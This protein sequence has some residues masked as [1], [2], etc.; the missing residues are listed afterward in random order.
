MELSMRTINS[1]FA[2]VA[3]LAATILNTGCQEQS[4][5]GVET[6]TSNNSSEYPPHQWETQQFNKTSGAPT[7][8]EGQIVNGSFESGDFLGWTA[9]TTSSP[10]RPWDVGATGTGGGFNMAF[11]AP[12]D[13]DFVAWHGFD[14][15]GPMTFSLYQDVAVSANVA[16]ELSWMER[17]QW[18][19]TLGAVVT[20][21]RSFAVQVLDPVDD[22]VLETLFSFSTGTQAEH[23]EG[24]TD[25]QSH[26]V[27]LSRYA[28]STVRIAF[29]ST[30]PQAFS[31]PAQVEIDAVSLEENPLAAPGVIDIKPGSDSNRIN[32]K[33]KGVIA[34]AILSTEQFNALDVDIAS[35]TFGPEG[36]AVA[37]R[38][39]V[40]DVD[41]DGIM[42]L[43]VHFRTQQAGLVRG[44]AQACLSGTLVD[45]TPFEACDMISLAPADLD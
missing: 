5:T 32:L 16:A 29:L 33:S 13:G 36:A 25:W 39:H 26:R 12:Q 14:G 18:N 45:S 7:L 10:F 9:V 15:A 27:D 3:A 4:L 2:I 19:F 21:P 30:V 1:K 28:G 31:G 22:T 34:V 42:D 23:P 38:G 37:H 8:A 40:E 11:T 6:A 35:L 24:D 17:V 44:Q 20:V 41:G 43:L